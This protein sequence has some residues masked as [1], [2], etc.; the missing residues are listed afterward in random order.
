MERSSTAGARLVRG[1]WSC[2]LPIHALLRYYGLCRMMAVLALA[3]AGIGGGGDGAVAMTAIG[4]C[5]VWL[6]RR[7][8]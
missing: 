6:M 8:A 1:G 5:A 7:L 4:V 3:M 2:L